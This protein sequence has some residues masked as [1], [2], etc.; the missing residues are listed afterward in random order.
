MTKPLILIDGSSYLYRAFHALPP[1][2]ASSGQPTGAVYGVANMIKRLIKD[3]AAEEIV[4]V[5]DA[6]GKTFRD[7]LYPEYKA[8]R[9]SIPKELS[10]QFAPLIAV[11]E[12]LGVPVLII[13][14]VEADDVIGTIANSAKNN[15]RKVIISTGDKDMAQ[16][17][18]SHI[19]LLNTM[20]NTSMDEQGVEEKFGVKPEQIIDYLTLV[21]DSSDNIP[22]V[23]KCGPKTA[24][25]WLQEYQTLD[26]LIANAAKIGGK[27]GEHLR[28]DIAKLALSKQLVTIKTDVKL[29]KDIHEYKLQATDRNKL[30]KLAQELEFKSWIQE[31]STPT[32]KTQTEYTTAIITTDEQ[33]DK[34]LTRIHQCALL[35]IDT[36]TTSLNSLEAKLVGI[37]L[38]IDEYNPAYIPL[39]HLS[40]EPQLDL[41]KVL[42]QLKPLL[43]DASIRK[44]GQNLKYDYQVFK[45]YNITMCGIFADTML[46]S[47]LLNST[48]QR[49]DL[50]TMALKYLQ[51]T[52]IKY[53]EVTTINGK[54]V[55]FAEVPIAT[56]ANYAAE[57]AEVTLKLHNTLTQQLA[58]PLQ[59][60]LTTLEVPILTILADMERH[61]VLVDLAQLQKHGTRLE[62]EIA[63]LSEHAYELVGRKFNLG[64]PKQLREIFYTELGLPILAKTPTGQAATSEPVLTE[65]AQ[66]YELPALIL[67][68]RTLSKLLS[69]YIIALQKKADQNSRVHTSYNQAVTATG[70]L[71]SSDPNLQNIPIKDEEGRLI[72]RAF[73]APA[74]HIL[75]AADYSQ[76][77]LRIMAHLSQDAALLNAF[78]NGLDIHSATAS[79]ILHIPISDV[80]SEQRRRAKA[81][82]FGLIYGMSAYGLAK[83]LGVERQEAQKYIDIYFNRYPGVLKYMDDTRKLAHEK[84]YVTTLYGRRLYLPEINA[85]NGLRRKAAE[86]AAINAPL[87]GTAADIIKKAMLNFVNWQNANQENGIIMIMQVHDELVFEVLETKQDL[88]RKEIKNIMENIPGLSVPLIVSIGTG[89]NWDE[90]SYLRQYDEVAHQHSALYHEN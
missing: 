78:A 28:N 42:R 64:S 19:S 81:V 60:I 10:S 52:T 21:G 16:L 12:A 30:L 45:N 88:A 46:E 67:R 49:H 73:I 54:E 84:G 2:V 66:D 36:E 85:G 90:T 55:N 24:C 5:F 87:Q 6:K 1:L 8:H 76:I 53:T 13:P 56:A 26:N 59:N 34:W 7:E 69:T 23:T 14:G 37:A 61:G 31:L 57:D 4:A 83:Q 77:E 68:H 17:V 82:N 50:D 71:S 41:N 47:Y 9:P 20:T 86:R 48:S 32:S 44:V 11:L 72:R 75:L 25:K 33:L 43:E 65:L 80:T 39:A 79:E 27:I 63:T 70:R 18:N 29:P 38:C 35:C 62:K 40:Q 15:Q 3:Y 74:K 51:H 22:G 58:E 89:K